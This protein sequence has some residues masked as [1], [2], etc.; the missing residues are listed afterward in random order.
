[1]DTTYPIPAVTATPA[2]TVTEDGIQYKAT[3]AWEEFISSQS[4]E[5][6]RGAINGTKISRYDVVCGTDCNIS[7]VEHMDV[8]EI[9][10]KVWDGTDKEY[11]DW[12]YA[13]YGASSDNPHAGKIWDNEKQEWVKVELDKWIYETVDL[14]KFQD[15][16]LHDEIWDIYTSI[17]PKQIIEE[18][19]TFLVS[20]DDAGGGAAHIARC[21]HEG[22]YGC[23]PPDTSNTKYVINF[24]P[25]DM[26]PVSGEREAYYNPGKLKDALEVDALKSTLIHE[27]AHI[28]S[29]SASQSDNDLLGFEELCDYDPDS[30]LSYLDDC[31]DEKI[32]QTITQKEAACAPNFYDNWAGCLKEDSYLNKFYQKFWA[33]I[34]REHYYGGKEV[35]STF[36]FHQKY[37]DHF[38]SNYAATNPAEDFAE[39]FTTFVLWDDELIDYYTKWC[40]SDQQFL[41]DVETGNN[42]VNED[43]LSYW[44]YCEKIYRDNSIWEEKIRFFYD[45]PKLVEMRDFIRSNL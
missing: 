9:I 24:D 22:A 28:M 10:T 2:T 37:Y 17:T 35:M 13:E 45:F 33:D 19:D 16:K 4:D 1:L 40:K 26:A 42:L 34:Y 30:T 21:I 3:N 41:S 7:L 43:G 8:D 39:S 15:K 6:V 38:V 12:W 44:I 5:E 14:K 25:I 11:D 18:I 36:D 29:L 31:D 32:R 20:T 23:G 27:N